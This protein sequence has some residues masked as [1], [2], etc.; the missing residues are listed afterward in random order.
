MKGYEAIISIEVR[1]VTFGSCVGIA[2]HP[3]TS[4]VLELALEML[5]KLS[6]HFKSR[7][8]HNTLHSR[9]LHI[10]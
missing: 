1:N 8:F 6:G 2:M 7:T 9:A 5:T 4:A 3:G 10:E